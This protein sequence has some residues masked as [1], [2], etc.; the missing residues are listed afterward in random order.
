MFTSWMLCSSFNGQLTRWIRCFLGALAPSLGLKVSIR[1]LTASNPDRWN[2]PLAHELISISARNMQNFGDL[3]AGEQIRKLSIS[4]F[5][6]SF[7][8][9]RLR[10]TSHANCLRVWLG[11]RMFFIFPSMISLIISSLV[12]KTKRLAKNYWPGRSND[13]MKVQTISATINLC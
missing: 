11:W 12:R 9:E 3:F 1:L 8:Y 13:N 2:D 6:F 7:Q 4:F 10:P 5:S